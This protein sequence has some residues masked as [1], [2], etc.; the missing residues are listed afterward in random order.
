MKTKKSQRGSGRPS[1]ARCVL[2]TVAV[3]CLLFYFT[4][5]VLILHHDKKTAERI[6]H[7]DE[8][9]ANAK[10]LEFIE[11]SKTSE[12]ASDVAES[13]GTSSKNDDAKGTTKNEVEQPLSS[14]VEGSKANSSS[15]SKQPHTD[16]VA[17]NY[18]LT[19]YLEPINQDDWKIKPLPTRNTKASDL[20]K[21]TFEK[22]NSCSNLP[23][24]FPINEDVAPTN[25]DPFLPW[26]HDVFP[27][28]DGK[29]VQFIAQNKRRCQT[30]TKKGEIKKFMQPNIALFQ[31]VP[32]K[33]IQI[34]DGSASGRWSRSENFG[35]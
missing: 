12:R 23:S 35:M 17:S 28:A 10:K 6:F 2:T 24:Q 1:F 26:I 33:R 14:D 25:K 3:T 32:I 31:H 22:V 34:S 27:S 30:G 20:E 15:Q 5:T 7:N 9:Y 19:S 29:F 13:G 21:V 18:I 11:N 8:H 16:S 4:A